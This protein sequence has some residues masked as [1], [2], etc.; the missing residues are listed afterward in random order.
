MRRAPP[1]PRWPGAARRGPRN[2]D[3]KCTECNCKCKCSLVQV[4]MLRLQVLL[5]VL[6]GSICNCLC[7]LRVK[8]GRNGG[9][10]CDD[11]RDEDSPVCGGHDTHLIESHWA[12]VK[13]VLRE[14]SPASPCHVTTAGTPVG[15]GAGATAFETASSHSTEKKSES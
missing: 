11:G 2:C 5:Q 14:V 6:A 4:Q 8:I 3:C 7:I 10:E 1:V 12:V 13:T 9:Q 15:V